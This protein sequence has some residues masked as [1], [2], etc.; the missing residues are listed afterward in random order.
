[1]SEISDQLADELASAPRTIRVGPMADDEER[2]VDIP[3]FE[4]NVEEQDVA[5]IGPATVYEVV[6]D[7]DVK[8]YRFLNDDDNPEQ[9]CPAEAVFDAM[10]AVGISRPDTT[11]DL[12]VQLGEGDDK[13]FVAVQGYEPA[14]VQPDGGFVSPMVIETGMGLAEFLS[15]V[16][17]GGLG[18]ARQLV[19]VGE[20]YTVENDI[21]TNNLDIGVYDDS[22]GSNGTGDAISDTNTLSSITT[23]PSD[24]NYSRQ[25]ENFAAADISG[26]W[27]VWT[28][29]DTVFDM[30]NT[31]GTI[32]SWFVEYNWSSDEAGST[33]DHLLCTGALSQNY[34][35]SNLTQLTVSAN[36]VG[37][38]IN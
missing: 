27:G 37:W 25:T 35:L 19:N 9:R 10:D 32:D 5:G 8:T 30:T 36:G 2:E 26:N 28:D 6:L 11:P 3:P 13:S 7:M 14:D 20:E 17:A 12:G 16:S 18:M 31:T 38:T 24:G 4:I 1:M 34:D 21:S 22:S 15:L 29:S 23:E 33:S